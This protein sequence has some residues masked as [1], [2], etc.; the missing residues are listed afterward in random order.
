[1]TTSGSPDHQPAETARDAPTNVIRPV[2]EGV[3]GAH[4]PPPVPSEPSAAGPGD[5]D[6][7]AGDPG[8]GAGRGPA[9]SDPGGGH[10]TSRSPT[11][12]DAEQIRRDI[13]RTREELGATVEQLVA[14]ADVRARVRSTAQQVS[15]RL[16]DAAT[17]VG[18]HAQPVADVGG[19]LAA[20][21]EV[22]REKLTTGSATDGLRD[23]AV[24]AVTALRDAAP[25]ALRRATADRRRTVVVV[26]LAAVA[27]GWL[28]ARR[29]RRA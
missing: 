12:G 1:M 28:A 22:A 29:R 4:H 23:Q 19:H 18:K 20:Q 15:H 11:P 26:A 17:S 5:A 13:E 14:K 16:Q 10:G 9:A 25:P 7:P 21:A 3:P 6:P 27:A 24:A 8:H 2:T